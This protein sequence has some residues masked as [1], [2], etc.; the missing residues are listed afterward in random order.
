VGY[1][2]AFPDEPAKIPQN[3][4]RSRLP[5]QHLIADA[6]DLLRLPGHRPSGVD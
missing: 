3:L 1:Q 6:V 4:L 5:P 2:A